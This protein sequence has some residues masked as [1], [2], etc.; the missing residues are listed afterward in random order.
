MIL[1][2]TMMMMM[3]MIANADYLERWG[4]WTGSS[5]VGYLTEQKVQSLTGLYVAFGFSGLER[6][7]IKQTGMR[8]IARRRHIGWSTDAL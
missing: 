2:L 6:K 7:E 8:W 4:E 3:M 5:E 1:V